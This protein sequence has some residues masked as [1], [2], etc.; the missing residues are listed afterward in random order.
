MV[1]LLVELLVSRC[2]E[3]GLNR[4]RGIG[5]LVQFAMEA[6]MDPKI[7][8]LMRCPSSQSRGHRSVESDSHKTIEFSAR[9]ACVKKR[10]RIRDEP[11]GGSHQTVV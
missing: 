2:G 1:L 4:Q 3:R 5:R 10:M 9:K 7:V 8:R 11:S 6:S